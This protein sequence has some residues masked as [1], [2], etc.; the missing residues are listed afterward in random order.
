MSTTMPPQRT[1]IPVDSP[2]KVRLWKNVRQALEAVPAYFRST[3]HIEGL[4]AGD[5]FNLNSVLGSTIEVQVVETLNRLRP[6]WDPDNEWPTY[7]FVRSA[8]TFPDVR[9]LSH[10]PDRDSDNPEIALGVELK[11]WYLLSKEGEPSFRYQVTPRACSPFDLLVVIPW[12]LQHVLSGVPVVY[13]PYIEQAGYAAEYRN[14]AWQEMRRAKGRDPQINPPNIDVTPYPPPKVQVNDKP[15]SDIGGNFG[16]V[17][18]TGLMDKYVTD[19]LKTPVAGIEAMHWVRFFK[20][21]VEAANP[22]VL[23]STLERAL[24]EMGRQVSPDKV[25]RLGVLLNELAKLSG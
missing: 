21:Y 18:R 2:A 6:V 16:R 7:Y 3:T 12:H 17:A 19:M 10:R 9:L 25:S 20:S 22:E 4:D 24:K 13:N 11:G 15:V 1:S 8:Q 5:L 23:R 14:W